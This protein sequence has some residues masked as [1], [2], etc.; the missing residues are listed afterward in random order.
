MRSDDPIHASMAQTREP[1]SSWERGL[2]PA[3]SSNRM[4]V[5]A[6]AVAAL[7]G[8][9]AVTQKRLLKESTPGSEKQS[10]MPAQTPD[11]G[12][13]PSPQPASKA[14][15]PAQEP[16]SRTH[17]VMR[18]ATR[19]GQVTYSDGPCPANARAE[20]VALQPDLNLA[21]GMT[22][23]AR[24]ASRQENMRVAQRQADHERR[25][26]AIVESSIKDECSWIDARISAL[27][28]AARQPL[29]GQWQDQI[30]DERR[31]LRDR[32]FALRCQ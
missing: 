6:L 4:L 25:M 14:A 17:H 26:A 22:A 28:A 16:S 32:Q 1:M 2:R 29:S 19:M 20:V 11:A 12:V 24:Q 31:K 15:R 10:R 18:C 8:M 30:R 27:D 7:I 21:D 13:L 23:S 3:K 5:L 9:V